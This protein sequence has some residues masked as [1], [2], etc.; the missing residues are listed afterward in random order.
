MYLQKLEEEEALEKERKEA[1]EELIREQKRQEEAEAIARQEAYEK[2]ASEEV[3]IDQT[4]RPIP[5][6]VT[7][8][9][10]PVAEGDEVEGE[11][12]VMVRKVYNLET[13]HQ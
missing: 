3:V 2:A 6:E 9:L 4:P 13:L 8:A 1:A 10:A 12:L 7:G 11:L 5:P